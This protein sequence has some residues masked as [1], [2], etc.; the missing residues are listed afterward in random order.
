M[1]APR[2]KVAVV[3]SGI[4]GLT[5]AH[6]LHREHDVTIFEAD[7]RIGG[8]S[9]TV[10]VQDPRGPASIDTGSTSSKFSTRGA[11]TAARAVGSLTIS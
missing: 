4:A 3:G 1:P 7:E 10:T 6:R 11:E 8:H 5:A 9:N 2:L